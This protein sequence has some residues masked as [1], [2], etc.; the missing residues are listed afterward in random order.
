M[1]TQVVQHAQLELLLLEE[2]D[3]PRKVEQQ[4]QRVDQQG[5]ALGIKTPIGPD[6]VG[7][8]THEAV[9]G[10][11]DDREGGDGWAP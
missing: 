4:L 1:L 10:G 7:C 8:I 5:A 2:D 9:Q 6:N 3:R 11:P